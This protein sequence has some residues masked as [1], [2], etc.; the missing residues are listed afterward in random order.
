[1]NRVTESFRNAMIEPKIQRLLQRGLAIPAC[2]LALTARRKF[3][4]RRQRAL[5]RYY[6]AAGVGGVAVGVHTTQFAIRDPK[7]GLFE[8]ILQLAAEEMNRANQSRREPLVKVAGICGKTKQAL[9]EASLLRQNGFHAGLLS[10]SAMKEASETELLKHCRAVAKIIPLFGFYLQPAVGGRVLPFSFWRRFAEIENL[11]AIKMAP[12]NR[13][14]T[15]DVVRALAE[16]GRDDVAL[17]TG[18]DDNIVL[19]LLTPYRFK[20]NG[21]V[22]Q[23]RIVGGLLGHWSVWTRRAVELLDQCHRVK[24]AAVPAQLLR[25]NVEVT[26]ANAAFFDAANNYA[27]CIAGLHEV[28][29]RQGLLKG[30]WCLDPTETLSRGQA[31]EID[32]VYRAYPHLNDD[33]FVRQ[34]LDE[35]LAG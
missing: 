28:L 33:V 13:Y 9:H 8:P 5:F 19:D 2:P 11:G 23:R 3:D 12:F 6:I 25:R 26:D 16:S 31:Q 14:Q 35:W 7:I 18:N 34:H 29:R 17:Y 22:V 27:G 20:V 32:R 24:G 21:R 15:L 30:I 10:L 4:E 1:L